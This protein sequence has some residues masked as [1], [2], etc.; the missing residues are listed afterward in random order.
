MGLHRPRAPLTDGLRGLK[1]C[2]GRVTGHVNS[3]VINSKVIN[4]TGRAKHCI[5]TEEEREGGSSEALV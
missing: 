4:A 5:S 2:L 3:K 1:Y